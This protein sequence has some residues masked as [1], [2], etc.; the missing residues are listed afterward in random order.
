M[1]G[2]TQN[3]A[4]SWE[5]GPAVERRAQGGQEG[6]GKGRQSGT[7]CRRG[8]ESPGEDALV[9]RKQLLTEKN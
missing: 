3:L 7:E 4:L 5:G 1:E 2:P 8:R 6:T 9:D